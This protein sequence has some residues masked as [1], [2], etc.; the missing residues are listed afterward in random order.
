M[1]LCAIFTLLN[2]VEIIT[3]LVAQDSSHPVDKPTALGFYC[4]SEAGLLIFEYA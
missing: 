1:L 2:V 3:G 4:I